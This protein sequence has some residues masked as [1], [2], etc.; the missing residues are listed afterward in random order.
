MD[1]SLIEAV[2]EVAVV[3]AM[4][5]AIYAMN[6]HLRPEDIDKGKADYISKVQVRLEPQEKVLVLFQGWRDT[7]LIGPLYGFFSSSWNAKAVEKG[8]NQF[9]DSNGAMNG[10]TIRLAGSPF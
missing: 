3:A 10:W 7:M 4:N 2:K 1:E 9:C 5:A 8:V 6:L